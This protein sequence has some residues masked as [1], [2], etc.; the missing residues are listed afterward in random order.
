M[1]EICVR[2]G[3]SYVPADFTVVNTGIE[4]RSP[5]I[6]RQP[7]LNTTRAIIYASN[8]K[9][10]FNIKGNREAFSFK[11]KTLSIPTQKE[12]VGGRN[13]SNT[14]NKAKTKNKGKQKAQKT[15]T[16]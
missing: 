1:E 13:K 14:Q 16:T 12:T 7:F 15:K 10:T 8:A 11:N 5:M 2:V 9:I 3:N 6:L 4:E